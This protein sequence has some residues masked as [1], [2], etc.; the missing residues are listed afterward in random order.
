MS[1]PAGSPSIGVAFITHRSRRHLAH[2]LPPILASPLAPR[3]LVVNSSSGDG[4][5]EEAQR[6]GAEVLVIPR[7]AFNHGTTRELARHHLGTDIVVMMTP[8]AYPTDAGML[9]RLVA[10]I[11]ERRAALAFARQIAHPGAGFFES[12]PREFNYPASSHTR[13]LA[14][15][16]TYGAYVVF[17][18]DSCAATLIRWEM[19]VTWR[20]DSI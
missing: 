12:F 7:R 19:S 20:T 1:L 8:D 17:C 9:G 4:T 3:V 18:S 15:A 11:V 6:L 13:V 14:D 10:P 2:C 16:A 5:V